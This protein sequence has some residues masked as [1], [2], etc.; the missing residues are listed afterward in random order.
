MSGCP[1]KLLPEQVLGAKLG[2]GVVSEVMLEGYYGSYRYTLV[3]T[4]QWVWVPNWRPDAGGL[5]A[6]EVR[7]MDTHGLNPPLDLL[8]EVRSDG[9][10]PCSQSWP[11]PTEL[12][13]T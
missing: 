4:R 10:L 12:G 1:R 11:L 5:G 6:A 9:T 7:G 8:R 2:G 13:G 3:P